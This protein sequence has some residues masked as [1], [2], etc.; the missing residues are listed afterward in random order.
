METV[1]DLESAMRYTAAMLDA[2]AWLR[3]QIA[4]GDVEEEYRPAVAAEDARDGRAR[5]ARWRYLFD[6]RLAAQLFMLSYDHRGQTRLTMTTGRAVAWF[7]E[8]PWSSLLPW[9]D[10]SALVLSTT[11]IAID[12]PEVDGAS[13]LGSMTLVLPT[14]TDVLGLI[15][16]GE[17]VITVG[18]HARNGQGMPV[19]LDE[20]LQSVPVTP[21]PSA[22]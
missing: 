11:P 21:V 10:G 8:L 9:Q 18:Y 3:R 17:N 22:A 5:R 16:D 14:S 7:G 12:L 4:Q 2:Q 15:T 1:T 6:P 19:V 20:T 13:T